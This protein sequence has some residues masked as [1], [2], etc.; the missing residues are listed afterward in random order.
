LCHHADPARR[1]ARR[2]ASPEGSLEESGQVPIISER[3]T[4]A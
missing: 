4:P 2:P 1:P 3:I